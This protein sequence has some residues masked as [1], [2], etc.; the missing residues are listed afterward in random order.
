MPARCVIPSEVR[1]HAALPQ[2][3]L[4]GLTALFGTLWVAAMSTGTPWL[5]A[6]PYLVLAGVF[7]AAALVVWGVR[8]AVEAALA[9]VH[10]QDARPTAPGAEDVQHLQDEEATAE[11]P[12]FH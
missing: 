8:R 7:L 6:G 1:R 5:E 10:P 11:R 9:L 2:A 4:L 12:P 3:M